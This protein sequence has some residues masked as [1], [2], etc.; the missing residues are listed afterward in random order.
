MKKSILALGI[1]ITISNLS[2]GQNTYP[3]PST[4]DIGIGTTTPME[5]LHVDGNV[6][7][8]DPWSTSITIGKSATSNPYIRNYIGFNLN[9]STANSRWEMWDN[10]NQGATAIMNSG[11]RLKFVIVPPD[12]LGGN[13]Y[14][15]NTDAAMDN[16]TLMRIQN[17]ELS[18]FTNPGSV[19]FGNATKDVNVFINGTLK[20]HEIEVAIDVWADYVF[21]DD[22]QLATLTQVEKYI[23]ENNHLPDVPSEKEVLKDGIKLGEMD[24][25]LLRKIEELTLYV[26]ELKKEL[27]TLKKH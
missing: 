14:F 4:G 24:A 19:I 15:Q 17:D 3:Y 20:A 9:Y 21:A 26:I 11:K 8:G 1:L 12:A 7:I 27:N 10:N 18:P 22:Y 5:K 13:N 23:T 16:F 6:R 25:I 2:Y